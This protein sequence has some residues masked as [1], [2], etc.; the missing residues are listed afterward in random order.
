MLRLFDQI[1]H[2][3]SAKLGIK[4]KLKETT[5]ELYWLDDCLAEFMLVNIQ[6]CQIESNVHYYHIDPNIG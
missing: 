1:N 5:S 6:C 2:R 4:W 3:V